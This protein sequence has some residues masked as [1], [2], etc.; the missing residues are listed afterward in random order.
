M[1]VM[2]LLHNLQGKVIHLKWVDR[3]MKKLEAHGLK[4]TF[5]QIRIDFF[6]FTQ[7]QNIL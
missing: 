5:N 3:R 7:T 4:I 6:S 2:K 1:R